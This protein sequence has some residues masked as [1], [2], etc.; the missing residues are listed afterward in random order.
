VVAQFQARGCNQGAGLPDGIFSNKKTIWV[1]FTWLICSH[2]GKIRAFSGMSL[3][4]EEM[5]DIDNNALIRTRLHNTSTIDICTNHGYLKGREIRTLQWSCYERCWSILRPCQR[6]VHSIASWQI[7][8][9]SLISEKSNLFIWW[10]NCKH[11]SK[12]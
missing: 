7:L 4:Q 9:N 6:S 12:I 8:L 3:F 2:E 11:V 1:V 5:E 10:T